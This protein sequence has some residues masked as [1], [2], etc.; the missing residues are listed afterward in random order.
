MGPFF[1][2]HN[3]M[4]LILEIDDKHSKIDDKHPKIDDKHS[5]IDDKKRIPR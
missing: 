2:L 4:D 3:Y 1:Y 5:K